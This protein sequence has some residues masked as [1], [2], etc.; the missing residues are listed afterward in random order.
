MMDEGLIPEEIFQPTLPARG[1]TGCTADCGSRGTHFNP[2]SPHG[3]RRPPADS[4]TAGAVDFNPRSPH[5]ERRRHARKGGFKTKTISTHAP[6]T[7]SD[8]PEQV[9]DRRAKRISTHAPRTGSD[10]AERRRE[11]CL[12]HFNPRSPH[13]ERRDWGWGVDSNGKPFQPTLPARGAT[14]LLAQY[15]IPC[16]FQPTLPARGATTIAEAQ[17]ARGKKFQPTLPARGATSSL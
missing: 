9:F 17:K 11:R 7:G 10:T 6:C 12:T 14:A 1:A 2:R 16:E 5:G 4:H 13:G 3:E 8:T 15:A